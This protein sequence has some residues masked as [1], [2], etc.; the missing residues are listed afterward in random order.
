MTTPNA[1]DATEWFTGLDQ[2]IA[3]YLQAVEA[4][5][6]PN[7]HELLERHPELAD[8]LRAFFADFDRVDLHAAP[9]RLAG[10]ADCLLSSASANATGPG[11]LATV[12][13]FGDYELLEEIARGGMGVVYKARQ[14]SLNR[15]VALKMILKGVLATPVDVARFRAEAESAAALDHPHIVPIHEVGEHEGQQYFAMRYVEGTTLARA[16]RQLARAEVDRLL[17]VARAVHFAH[18]RGI[19]HRDLKPSNVLIDPAGSAFVTDFGLAKRTGADASLTETG[20]PVGTPRY[21]APEQAAGRKDLTV[22]VDVYSLGV[23]LYERLTGR[24]PF[25]GDNMLEV[26]RQVRETDPPRPSSILPNL[27]RD[28]ETICLKCLEKDP[29]RRYASA[30]ALA[31]DLDRWLK[32][33]AIAARPVG[34]QERAWL[35][36]R[37]NPALATAGGLTLAALVAVAVTSSIAAFQALARANAERRER[38]VARKAAQD[39]IASRDAVQKT[40]ARSL[41]SPLNPGAAEA[42]TSFP[43]M[44]RGGMGTPN[45]STFAPL[46]EPESEALWELAEH[47]GEGLWLRYLSEATDDPLRTRQLIARAEPALIAALGLDRTKYD[48]AVRLLGDRCREPTIVQEQKAGVALVALQ[49]ADQSSPDTVEWTEIIGRAMANHSARPDWNNLLADA[50]DR[51]E[52]HVAC[53]VLAAALGHEETEPLATGLVAVTEAMDPTE[54]AKVLSDAIE[55]VKNTGTPISPMGMMMSSMMGNMMGGRQTNPRTVLVS[56]LSAVAGRLDS[57]QGSKILLKCMERTNNAAA[58]HE[59][60]QGIAAV[61]ERGNRPNPY[62]CWHSLS[63][64]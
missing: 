1:N 60:A 5:Q 40:Y 20:Q 13:Y 19:L 38:D 3:Q 43:G 52:Q 61:A 46:N 51:M 15:I 31:E 24:P 11:V 58:R 49:L 55:H 63:S 25:R 64:K 33:E 6:V 14:A 16:P 8:A 42:P 30:E 59:L 56:G 2:V 32:G 48:Q 10:D 53:R 47:P 39:A 34:R 4:G 28:L 35:W 17:D 44:M 41:V 27:D 54:A 21:M 50:A 18:Q 45:A 26:L 9:L 23:I 36:S 62:G 7:R 57:A 37:R 29:G 22:G 12:R